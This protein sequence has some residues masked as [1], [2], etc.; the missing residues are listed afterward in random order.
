MYAVMTLRMIFKLRSSQVEQRTHRPA[1]R[2]ENPMHDN[3]G[4]LPKAQ[5]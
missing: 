4:T 5:N 1:E 3:L 2:R